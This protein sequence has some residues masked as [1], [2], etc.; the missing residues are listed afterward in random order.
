MRYIMNIRHLA[1]GVSTVAVLSLTLGLVSTTNAHAADIK[2]GKQVHDQNCIHCHASIV[3]GDGT[4]I[5]TRADRRIDSLA[6]L[7]TQ[8]HRC[9]N[10]L[11][12]SLPEDQIQDVVA[13]LNHTFYHF[14]K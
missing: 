14:K 9:K 11:G 3:G 4:A 1:G 13:Y 10:G 2:R 12:V 6:A 7:N 8:V 5:Y